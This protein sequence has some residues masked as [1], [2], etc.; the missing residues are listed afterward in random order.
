MEIWLWMIVAALL[1][2][3]LRLGA[4][5]R[6]A[7]KELWR[8]HK[9]SVRVREASQWFYKYDV[10][11][12]AAAKWMLCEGDDAGCSVDRFRDKHQKRD[13]RKKEQ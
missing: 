11:A 2:W 1:L 4:A 12:A 8:L 10:D 13:P 7:D 9:I 3:S 5:L 6:R